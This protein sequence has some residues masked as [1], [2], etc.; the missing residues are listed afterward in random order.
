M[1]TETIQT[2]PIEGGQETND[3][4]LREVSLTPYFCLYDNT[5]LCK[6]GP[7]AIVQG[8]DSQRNAM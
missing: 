7:C 3:V 4:L 6:Y 2:N 1:G 5:F 8:S